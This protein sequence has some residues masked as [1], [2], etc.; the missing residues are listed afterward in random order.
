MTSKFYPPV[1]E[2]R[3]P[4][5]GTG[6]IRQDL[7]RPCKSG[8]PRTGSGQIHTVPGKTRTGPGQTCAEYYRSGQTWTGLYTAT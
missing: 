1:S 8:Q 5:F 6:H 7:V 4:Q 2:R 3:L